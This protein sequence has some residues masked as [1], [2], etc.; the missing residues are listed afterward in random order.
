MRSSWDAETLLSV[1]EL[2]AD[3]SS[4]LISLEVS[5]RRHVDDESLHRSYVVAVRMQESLERLITLL[6]T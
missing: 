1:R 5:R 3:L 2:A 4:L 6:Q